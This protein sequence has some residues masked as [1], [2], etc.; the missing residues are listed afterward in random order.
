LTNRRMDAVA[1]SGLLAHGQI[2]PCR[3]PLL[4]NAARNESH[5]VNDPDRRHRNTTFSVWHSL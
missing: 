4:S 3:R 2:A 5:D 1:A